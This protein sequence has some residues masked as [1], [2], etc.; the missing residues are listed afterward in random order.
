MGICIGEEG[1]TGTV[2]RGNDAVNTFAVFGIR[3]TVFF[4]GNQNRTGTV[5]E[6]DGSH[7]CRTG[8]DTFCTDSRFKIA[9]D[10]IGISVFEGVCLGDDK[11]I[12][13]VADNVDDFGLVSNIDLELRLN[14][15]GRIASGGLM[16][17]SAADAGDRQR[18]DD[19]ESTS[20]KNVKARE[21]GIPILSEDDFIARFGM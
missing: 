17:V 12:A 15:G 16:V 6:F 19:L 10:S 20:S 8:V 9:A 18:S 11:G 3:E 21:L 2:Q 7:L 13:V 5:A 1:E 14:I 4:S